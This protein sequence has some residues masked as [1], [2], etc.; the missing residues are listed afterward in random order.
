MIK[1]NKKRGCCNVPYSVNISVTERCPLKCPF[2]FHKYDNYDELSFS[3]VCGYIDEL[4]CMGTAQIQ[5]SGGEPLV[6][7]HILESISYAHS[8]GIR[9]VI[10]TS[11][12]TITEESARK[13]KEA[14]LDCCYISL[15]G[16]TAEIH[17]ITRDGY[18][19]AI[20]ALGIF[21]KIGLTSA[22]NWVASHDNVK[23]LKNVVSLAKSLGVKHISVIPMKKCGSNR[24][25]REITKEDLD[26]LMEN[27]QRNKDYLIV[28]SCFEELM[29]KSENAK[30]VSYGCRAGKF[31]MA[32]SAQGKF[33]CCPHMFNSAAETSSIEEYWNND[34][35]LS[36]FRHG[37]GYSCVSALAEKSY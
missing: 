34:E 14:G 30:S 22:I 21:K 18:R 16:S 8:K 4:V 24:T 17:E 10:S 27:C 15:N 13:L 1:F 29:A 23:D 7:P 25:F 33:L 9:V 37:R 26:V 20:N 19:F 11:G 3:Q 32:I 6:Y 12:V 36:P 35:F 5:F 31:Y 28:E 2:C